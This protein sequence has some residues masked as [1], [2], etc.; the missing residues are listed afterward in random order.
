MTLARHRPAYLALRTFELRRAAN[1]TCAHK[2]NVLAGTASAGAAFA[3]N[4]VVNSY[5]PTR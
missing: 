4:T 2:K 5:N 1:A 3:V